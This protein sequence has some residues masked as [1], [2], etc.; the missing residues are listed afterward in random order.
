MIFSVL[1]LQYALN[2]RL[3]KEST[4]TNALSNSSSSSAVLEV[5]LVKKENMYGYSD[6]GKRDFIRITLAQPRF[7]A[8]AKRI[9]ESGLQVQEG[10]PMI[11]FGVTFETNIDF[12]I[13][14]MIDVKVF[15]C[16]WI[17]LPAGKYRIRTSPR[18]VV[19]RSSCRPNSFLFFVKPS[20][21]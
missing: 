6:Q 4:I 21:K 3:L 1:S 16:N 9:F 8:A 15:G 17:E 5:N 11:N 18:D 10:G 12:E 19:G 20:V 13:R 7:I 14:F 2:Q